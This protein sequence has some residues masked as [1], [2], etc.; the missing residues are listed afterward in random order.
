MYDA[1]S[2]S[3]SIATVAHNIYLSQPLELAGL[4]KALGF[5]GNLTKKHHLLPCMPLHIQTSLSL[6]R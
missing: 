5:F 6:P 1:Y 4:I 2:V 3:R